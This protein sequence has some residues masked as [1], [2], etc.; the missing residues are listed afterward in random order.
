MDHLLHVNIHAENIEAI[1]MN[2]RRKLNI[3]EKMDSCAEARKQTEEDLINLMLYQNDSSDICFLVTPN[4]DI[5]KPPLLN[6]KPSSIL[7]KWDAWEIMTSET[8]YAYIYA[9]RHDRLCEIVHE[10]SCLFRVN[11]AKLLNASQGVVNKVRAN[12]A[13]H[14]GN[15]ALGKLS[16]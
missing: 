1:K 15:P 8:P 16:V 2:L 11:L 5:A 9:D 7:L 12:L 4:E 14:G 6:I 10:L 3:L 13:H